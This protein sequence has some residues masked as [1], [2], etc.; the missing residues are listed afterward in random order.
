MCEGAA[1]EDAGGDVAAL[2]EVEQHVGE[3]SAVGASL[4]ALP[5]RYARHLSLPGRIVSV[6][7]AAGQL[8][9]VESGSGMIVATQ[10]E[11][12]GGG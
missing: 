8:F 6:R 2:V 7:Q 10:M 12:W 9:R 4:I 11:L 5:R 1:Q 3:Q